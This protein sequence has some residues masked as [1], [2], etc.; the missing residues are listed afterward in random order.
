MESETDIKIHMGENDTSE[1]CK[2]TIKFGTGT[3]QNS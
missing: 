1:I 3:D 2:L